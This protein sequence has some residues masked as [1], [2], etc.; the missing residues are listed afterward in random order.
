MFDQTRSNFDR[1]T[2]LRQFF[3][4]ISSIFHRSRCTPSPPKIPNPTPPSERKRKRDTHC[5][6]IDCRKKKQFFENRHGVHFRLILVSFKVKTIVFF[7]G[8]HAPRTTKKKEERKEKIGKTVWQVL[9]RFLIYPPVRRFVVRLAWIVRW[10]HW[11]GRKS[12][13]HIIISLVCPAARGACGCR[14]KTIEN[15]CKILIIIIIV[16]S[17]FMYTNRHSWNRSYTMIDQVCKFFFFFSY[18]FF[19][20][21]IKLHTHKHTQIDTYVNANTYTLTHTTRDKCVH[22]SC[23]S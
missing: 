14:L 19:P 20:S 16:L 5:G 10:T 11:N 22:R 7:T 12:L 6:K 13:V 9:S 4:A 15:C 2:V 23:Y 21:T 3:F 1:E 18:F 17:R 8:N